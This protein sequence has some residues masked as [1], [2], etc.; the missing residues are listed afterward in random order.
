MWQRHFGPAL[1][2]LLLATVGAGF[3]FGVA[4]AGYLAVLGAIAT[5]RTEDLDQEKGSLVVAIATGIRYLRFS[6]G[7]LSHSE[8]L[9]LCPVVLI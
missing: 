9:I 8:R 2:G 7:G 6:R 5:A 1:G 4:A 3:S